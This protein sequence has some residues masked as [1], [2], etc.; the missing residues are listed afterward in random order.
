[1][2][3]VREAKA[4]VT[5]GW[6]RA[7]KEG[8]GTLRCKEIAFGKYRAPDPWFDVTGTI[9]VRRL[10]PNSRKIEVEDMPGELLQPKMLR[11]MGYELANVH[12]GTG[13]PRVA[14]ARDLKTRADD[15][16]REAAS[17]AAEFVQNEFDT[18]HKG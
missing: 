5:S 1:G 12:L 14:I 13:N 3:V 17:R 10:S 6:I 15:W 8:S 2:R 16:L 18:W 9:A 4:L 7:T 11:A